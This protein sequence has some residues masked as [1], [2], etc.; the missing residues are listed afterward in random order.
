MNSNDY[1][2]QIDMVDE[3]LA[4]E[5]MFINNEFK[6][7]RNQNDDDFLDGGG[8]NINHTY[9]ETTESDIDDIEGLNVILTFIASQRQNDYLN[10]KVENF[11]DQNNHNH[12]NQED[13]QENVN[14][15]SRYV[16]MTNIKKSFHMVI[17]CVS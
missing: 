6:R 1:N 8:E 13:N 11:N 7:S 2:E 16:L 14:P 12:E 9:N 17:I 5:Q 10:T 4:N 3:Q 15:N